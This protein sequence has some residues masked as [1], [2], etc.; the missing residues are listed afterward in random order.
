MNIELDTLQLT[1]YN[2]EKHKEIL[3]ELENGISSSKFIHQIR[4]RLEN[5]NNNNS[6]FQSAFIILDN[7]TPIG[8]IYISSMIRDEVFLEY[9][10]L[11]EFRRMGY[12]TSV[13]SELSD[14]LFKNHNIKSIRLDIDPSNKSS[15]L[16]ANASGYTLDEEEFESRNY[17]GKMQFIKESYCY[18]S[19][20]RK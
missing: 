12:A 1:K 4:E 19:K 17:I 9:S 14:Y 7:N 16:V 2:K 8:Y 6:L 10:I 18:V 5:S 15:I 13:V 11:K 3:D 20:R